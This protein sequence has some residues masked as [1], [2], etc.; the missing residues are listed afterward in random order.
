MGFDVWSGGKSEEQYVK[1]CT[2]SKKYTTG[3]W[4]VLVSENV[5]V[6]SLIVYESQ[7]RIPENFCGI[8]SVATAIQHRNKGHSSHLINGVCENLKRSGYRGVY[9]HSD[10]DPE[11]YKRL[12]FIPVSTEGTNCMVRLFGSVR[13]PES[14]IPSYF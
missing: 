8:G 5:L 13:V 6:S 12:G 4:Y 9:L 7:F 3:T 1:E 2:E 14:E 11:F 10:I